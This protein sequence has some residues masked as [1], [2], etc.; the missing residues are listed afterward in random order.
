[1]LA[2]TRTEKPTA[3]CGSKVVT[4]AGVMTVSVPP[5]PSLVLLL[6]TLLVISRPAVVATQP[7]IMDAQ[8]ACRELLGSTRM[9]EEGR[10]GL[11]QLLESGQAPDVMDRLIHLALGSG[12]GDVMKG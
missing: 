5:R 1:M 6:G 8:A 9:T 10:R 7:P 11:R 3:S 12:E 2:K 4:S